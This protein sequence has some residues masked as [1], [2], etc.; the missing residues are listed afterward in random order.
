MNFDI[1]TLL[2]KLKNVVLKSEIDQA[3]KVSRSKHV[4]DTHWYR[5]PN[6]K[7]FGIEVKEYNMI[8]EFFGIAKKN[9]PIIEISP[10]KN[11]KFNIYMERQIRR[12]RKLK[13]NPSKF[14]T[15]T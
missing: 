3:K 13:S 8:F 14:F 10:Y 7:H 2:S 6:V 1:A 11:A 15:V 9:N 4:L 5:I 12:L